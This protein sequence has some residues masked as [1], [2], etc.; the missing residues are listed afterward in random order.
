MTTNDLRF[1][2][3]T[4]FA[5]AFRNSVCALSIVALTVQ[6]VLAQSL[7]GDGSANAPQITMTG[8]GVPLVIINTPGANGLSYNT[9]DQFS[10]G[11]NGV[12]LNNI[13]TEFGT[14]L[15]GGLIAGNV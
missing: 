8:N 5:T 2:P 4:K 3:V 10:V 12:I 6:P 11:P 14:S 13:A 15:Q 7:V 1:C 9:Y